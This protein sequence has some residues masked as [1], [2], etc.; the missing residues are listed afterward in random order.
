MNWA[1]NASFYQLN[2]SD[3]AVAIDALLKVFKNDL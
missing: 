2:Y 1:V 3:S